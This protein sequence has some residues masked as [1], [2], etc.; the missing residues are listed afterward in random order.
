MSTEGTAITGQLH[1]LIWGLKHRD[2]AVRQRAAEALV[3]IGAP[4]VPALR[5]AALHAR[6]E[7]RQSALSGLVRIGEPA[8]PVLCEVL[9]HKALDLHWVAAD[10][11]VRIGPP[12]VANLCQLL[13]SPRWQVR[14]RVAEALGQIG[15]P[16]ALG[17]LSAALRD[18]RREV[19]LRALEAL[20]ATGGEAAATC[21]AESMVEGWADLS[22]PREALV[23]IGPLAVPAL[24]G[25]LED[26]SWEVRGAAVAALGRIGDPQVVP[27]LAE[28]LQCDPDLGVRWRAAEA[29][30]NIRDDGVVPALIEALDD[31]LPTV[32]IVVVDALEKLKDPQAVPALNEKLD[33]PD[34]EVRSSA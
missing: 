17:P 8:V 30:G 18:K 24:R 33:D 7:V 4:A 15:D 25:L 13:Q 34:A 20:A 9:E 23:K 29:L 3:E 31:P 19:C 21:I 1:S 12:A 2:Y 32:R 26:T 10:A 14:S 22:V 28:R 16:S 11:L 6:Y 27:D 5:E